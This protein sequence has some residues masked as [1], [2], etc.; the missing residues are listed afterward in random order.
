MRM[1]FVSEVLNR[2]GGIVDP[3]AEKPAML[4]SSG[5]PMEPC[6]TGGELG[7]LGDTVSSSQYRLQSVLPSVFF[8]APRDQQ[9][10]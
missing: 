1:S 3:V 2:G 7:T 4:E 6:S 10:V 5:P 9:S 8:L